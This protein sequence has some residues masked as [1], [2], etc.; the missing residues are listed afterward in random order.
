MS[1]VPTQAERDANAKTH[2]TTPLLE[3]PDVP[4]LSEAQLRGKT[5]EEI[6]PF[7]RAEY[8]QYREAI[9]QA[10]YS[11]SGWSGSA[12]LMIRHN[13]NWGYTSTRSREAGSPFRGK[14]P[15]GNTWEFPMNAPLAYYRWWRGIVLKNFCQ[16][17]NHLQAIHDRVNMGIGKPGAKVTGSYKTAGLALRKA[18]GLSGACMFWPDIN[19]PQHIQ[20]SCDGYRDVWPIE[21]LS[22]TGGNGSSGAGMIT[23]P[24][25]NAGTGTGIIAGIINFFRAIWNAILS[26][27]GKGNSGS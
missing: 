22:P 12:P 25:E 2:V 5:Y 3:W 23:S 13:Y 27:F 16:D 1:C 17:M 21:G 24:N 6:E 18:T 11:L 4:G 19:N 15:N 26:M 14:F 10:Y 20:N 8:D 9:Q 7:A